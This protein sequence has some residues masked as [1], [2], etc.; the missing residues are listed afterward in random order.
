M[1]RTLPNV[2]S[3]T[4]RAR[5]K[6]LD[7]YDRV[8]TVPDDLKWRPVQGSGPRRY[9]VLCTIGDFYRL[10]RDRDT[11]EVAYFKR[12]D[13]DQPKSPAE[14]IDEEPKAKQVRYRVG[15]HCWYVDNGKWFL[16]SVVERDGAKM[17]LK[18][19]TGWDADRTKEWPVD[20]LFHLKAGGTLFRRLRPLKARYL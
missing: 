9:T 17:T 3:N 1:P 19:V 18:S 4:Y 6:D 10:V 13:A 8:D 2:S 11:G 15:A 14:K 20:V 7:Q 12:K 16:M 5:W